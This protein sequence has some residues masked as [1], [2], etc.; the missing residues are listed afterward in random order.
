[1]SAL[2]YIAH[3]LDHIFSV[4]RAVGAEADFY[5]KKRAIFS[6]YL[7]LQTW[8]HGAH[9]WILRV[10]RAIAGVNGPL[11]FRNQHFNGLTDEFVACVAKYLLRG[12]ID[13]S[14]PSF[15]INFKNGV[16]RGFQQTAKPVLIEA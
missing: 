6:L 15:S 9:L 1:M 11:V 3:N 5:G 12:L 4:V 13:Q 10:A 14:D 16:R 2:A 7:K 8:P